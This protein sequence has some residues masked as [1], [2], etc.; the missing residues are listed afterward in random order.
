M[1]CAYSR[2]RPKQLSFF[3]FA[4]KRSRPVFSRY[5]ADKGFPYPICSPLY[6]ES[7]YDAKSRHS[8]FAFYPYTFSCLLTLRACAGR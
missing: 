4:K 5:I 3:L 1:T 6:T 7:G 8:R 2:A